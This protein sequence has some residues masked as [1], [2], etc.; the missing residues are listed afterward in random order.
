MQ[1]R[2][3]S[4]MKWPGLKNPAMHKDISGSLEFDGPRIV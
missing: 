2:M 1:L 4:S 3:P